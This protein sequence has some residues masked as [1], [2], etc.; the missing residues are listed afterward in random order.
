[1]YYDTGIKC[2]IIKE[3]LKWIPTAEGWTKL[4][5]LD[6]EDDYTITRSN[7][8]GFGL[9]GLGYI[10]AGYSGGAVGSTW[11]YDPALAEWENITT[12]EATA[13]QD[14]LSF[15]TGSRAFV[16]LGRSGSLYLDDAY[17]IFPQ[18]DYDDED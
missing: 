2:S 4:N 16:L 6:E 3:L 8:V 14:A 10:V 15:T 18:E 7:A 5:D 17:E 13:R 9:N 12:L 11:E 1:M